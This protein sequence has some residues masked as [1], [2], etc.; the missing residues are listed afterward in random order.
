MS[1]QKEAVRNPES[2]QEALAKSYQSIRPKVDILED[3]NGITLVADLPGVSRERLD[4]EIDN[5]ILSIDG[6]V[7]LPVTSSGEDGSTRTP[8]T[9]YQRSFSLSK[10]LDGEQIEASLKDGVL[11][12]KIPKRQEFKARKIEIRT[13]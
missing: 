5:E 10:E 11:A 4:I 13:R 12:M 2:R 6:E 1:Q 3:K 9:R 8:A 7:V